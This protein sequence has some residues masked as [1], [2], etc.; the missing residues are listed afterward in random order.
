MT[1]IIVHLSADF[2][3][4]MEPRKTPAILRLVESAPE[5]RHAVYSLNRVTEWS[6]ITG[7]PFGSDRIALAYGALPRGIFWER[8]LHDVAQWIKHDLE[9]KNIRPDLIYAHKFTVEGLTGQELADHFNCPLVCNI[10]GNTDGKILRTKILSRARYKNIA[11][12]VARVFP[13]SPWAAQPF[14]TTLGLDPLKCVALPV[15]PAH[16]NLSPAEA[17]FN[18][19]VITLFNLDQWRIK[20]LTQLLRGLELSSACNS[21]ITLDIYGSGSAKSVRTISRLIKRYQVEHAV[22]LM[23][24]IDNADVHKMLKNYAALVMP[25]RAESYGLVY[26]EALFAGIPIMWSKGHGIDGFLPSERIGYAV[27]PRDHADIAEGLVFLTEK[28]RLLKDEISLLQSQGALDILRRDHIV[29]T[30]KYHLD[31][32]LSEE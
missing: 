23:G 7:I 22:R 17:H 15:I 30:W 20:N 12:R 14:I 27:N 3:D 18:E 10:Q 8:R 26:A 21:R 32:V 25:S 1:K 31:R 16:D 19:A 24:P 29:S 9:Q 13:F 6:G 5:Y 28:E 4:P 2:P 11:A